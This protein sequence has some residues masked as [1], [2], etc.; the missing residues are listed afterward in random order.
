[1]VFESHVLTGSNMSDQRQLLRLHIILQSAVMFSI[2][3]SWNPMG[4]EQTIIT[5][6]KLTRLCLWCLDS[7]GNM[8]KRYV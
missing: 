4:V 8:L 7:I 3:A 6:D 2:S 5:I 1:M